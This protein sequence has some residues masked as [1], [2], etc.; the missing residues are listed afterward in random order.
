MAKSVIDAVT[1]KDNKDNETVKVKKYEEGE[2]KV[3]K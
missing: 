2:V 3:G 1:T